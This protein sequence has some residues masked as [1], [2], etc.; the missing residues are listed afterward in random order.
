MKKILIID[1][2]PD[3]R[4]ER[5]G[6]ALAAAYRDGALAA[7][8][9]VRTVTLGNLD[10][11]LLRTREE[12]EQQSAPE[13]LRSSQADIMW[14]EHVVLIFPLWLGSVP[15][16]VKAYLEQVLRPDFAFV[17]GKMFGKLKGRSVRIITTM[18]MPSLV[19]RWF[20]LSHGMKALKRNIFQFVGMRPVR[21]SI[22]GMVEGKPAARTEHLSQVKRLG[23]EA[24]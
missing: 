12:W 19:Y 9:E 8:H 24:R 22:I 21:I 4:P 10:I 13:S 1:G 11:P 7:G 16:L 14:A 6:H 5:F 3:S 20:F 23:R 15:A 18:G 17:E 2:H